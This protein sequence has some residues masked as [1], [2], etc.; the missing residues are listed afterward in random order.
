MAMG[1]AAGNACA[2]SL[3]DDVLVRNVDVAK[4]QRKLVEN[5]CNIGQGFRKI[6]ALDDADY[7]E[8]RIIT[9]KYNG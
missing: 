2:I 8:Y 6:E 4:L 5:K 1:E 9:K 7:S 3:Q